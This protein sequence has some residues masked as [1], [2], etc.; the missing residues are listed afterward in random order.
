M[1]FGLTVSDTSINT[2]QSCPA[3]SSLQPKV[4][5]DLW[6]ASNLDPSKK[7]KFG[8]TINFQ[9]PS[10]KQLSDDNDG[11]HRFDEKFTVVCTTRG[12]YDTPRHWPQCVESCPIRI[13]YV[14]LN[15]TGLIGVQG[16]N[17]VPS[18]KYGRY[19]CQ[20]T[21]L[22]VDRG[23]SEY[24][25]VACNEEG[26]YE[27]PKKVRDWPICMIRTTTMSPVLPIAL[28]NMM[29]AFT[30]RLEFRLEAYAW[31]GDGPKIEVKS[32]NFL[33][34]ITVPVAIGLGV[35]VLLVLC[36]VRNDSIFCKICEERKI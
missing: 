2:A 36:I 9:C 20:D 12:N 23:P 24:F 10:T 35:F 30:Q 32:G 5:P 25:Q 26:N 19:I 8:T 22:G 15:K 28:K 7:P 13:P 1:P 21:T 34:K 18:G 11:Y 27:V 3:I 6:Q 4:S 31:T 33:M 29:S 14:P 17:T 16:M